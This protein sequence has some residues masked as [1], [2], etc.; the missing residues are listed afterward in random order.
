MAITR[1]QSW[2]GAPVHT[3]ADLQLKYGVYSTSSQAVLEKE[4]S[5]DGARAKE[6][7][8]GHER[9]ELGGERSGG[10]AGAVRGA[11][12]G[13]FGWL[14]GFQIGMFLPRRRVHM[15]DAGEDDDDEE[16]RKVRRGIHTPAVVKPLS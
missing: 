5:G 1:R 8:D 10:E 16:G 11:L 4:E 7:G 12:W 13:L 14:L 6:E 15:E 3:L 2:G 9:A